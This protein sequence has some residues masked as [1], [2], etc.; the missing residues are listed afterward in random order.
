VPD[1]TLLIEGLPID[2]LIGLIVGGT[3]ETTPEAGV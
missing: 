1:K 2:A 3:P